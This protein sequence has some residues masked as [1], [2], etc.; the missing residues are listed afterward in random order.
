MRKIALQSLAKSAQKSLS[1]FLQ[2][3]DNQLIITNTTK[4]KSA[5]FFHN[6]ASPILYCLH[7]AIG[8]LPATAAIM[9][10]SI[11]IYPTQNNHNK[12]QWG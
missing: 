11:T 4:N 3:I 6:A 10:F 8:Y 2:P 12:K 7:A 9:S 1:I 5:Q